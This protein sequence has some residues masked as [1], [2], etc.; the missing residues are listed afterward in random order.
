MDFLQTWQGLLWTLY[1]IATG[2]ILGT[3][4]TSAPLKRQIEF[5]QS[6]G[7]ERTLLF[8]DL[9]RKE[10]EK[11]KWLQAKVK[12][13]ESDLDRMNQKLIAQDSHPSG[14]E[15][16]QWNNSYWKFEGPKLKDRV[17]YLEQELA[18]AQDQL[19]WRLQ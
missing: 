4:W 1:C 3:L 9:Y 8:E 18:K 12:A 10:Q 5:L 11:V 6:A 2:L 14:I 15:A 19:M 16:P 13:Q 7:M 17:L